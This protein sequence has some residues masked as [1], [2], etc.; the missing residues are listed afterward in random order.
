MNVAE[1]RESAAISKSISTGLSDNRMD[2]CLESLETLTLSYWNF[3]R[4]LLICLGAFPSITVSEP[5]IRADMDS[6][7]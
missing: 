6:P 1:L 4:M 2:R 3:R 7:T 5:R